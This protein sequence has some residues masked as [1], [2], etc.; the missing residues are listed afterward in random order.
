MISKLPSGEEPI[1]KKVAF[2]LVNGKN[3]IFADGM[4]TEIVDADVVDVSFPVAGG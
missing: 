2:I 1:K 3:C 4:D